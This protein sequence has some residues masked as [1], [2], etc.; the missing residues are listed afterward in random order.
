MADIKKL[1]RQ[2]DT[3]KKSKQRA[4]TQETKNAA[5]KAIENT[6]LEMNALGYNSQG[7]PLKQGARKAAALP[8]CPRH[9]YAA[10]CL[11]SCRQ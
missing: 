4:P 5:Q 10:Q 8:G 7:K 9:K 11:P 3:L 6:V 1:K 2:Y